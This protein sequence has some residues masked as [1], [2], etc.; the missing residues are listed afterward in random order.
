MITIRP[1]R[2]SDIEG[3]RRTLDTVCRERKYLAALEAPEMERVRNFVRSNINESYTQFV[4]E[5]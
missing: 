5:E 1:I 2:E 3:F 4:A